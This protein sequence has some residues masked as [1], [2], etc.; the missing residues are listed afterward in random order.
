MKNEVVECRLRGV[1]ECWADIVSWV[2]RQTN[3]K[4]SILDGLEKSRDSDDS[5][6]MCGLA[7][8]IYHWEGM[9]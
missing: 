8:S 3:R 7:V 6:H 5:V 9:L 4:M 2:S 1:M